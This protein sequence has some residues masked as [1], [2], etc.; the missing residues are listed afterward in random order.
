M[1]CLCCKK[2]LVAIGTARKNGKK[3]SDWISRKYHKKCW[4]EKYE[5]DLLVKKFEK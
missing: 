2:R 5:F 4:I 3:H 1:Y